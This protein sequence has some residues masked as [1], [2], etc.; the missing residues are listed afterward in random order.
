LNWE[1]GENAGVLPTLPNGLV[2]DDSAPMA[3]VSMMH[4][5]KPGEP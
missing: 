2:N 4:E 3:P 1:R 5:L